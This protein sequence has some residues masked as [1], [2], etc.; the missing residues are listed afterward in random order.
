MIY[1]IFIYNKT[2]HS[3]NVI[4]LNIYIIIYT[5][6]KENIN[7]CVQHFKKQIKI[8]CCA[9]VAIQICRLLKINIHDFSNMFKLFLRKLDFTEIQLS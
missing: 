5:R 8:K 3:N 4:S 1:S 9:S 6:Y 7:I 2:I